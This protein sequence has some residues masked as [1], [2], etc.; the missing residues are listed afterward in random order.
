MDCLCAGESFRFLA[1]R[2]IARELGPDGCIALPIYHAFS[3]C[4]T[5][6]HFSGR[7]KRTAWDTLNAYGNVTHAFCALVARPTPQSIQEWL[8]PL[9]Q[10]VILIYDRTSSINS[11]NG[12][13]SGCLLREAE[14]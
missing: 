4:N 1:C 8:T 14:Q 5:V 11:V 10:F 3:G 2:E 9:E 13:E 7:G 6:S 12:K